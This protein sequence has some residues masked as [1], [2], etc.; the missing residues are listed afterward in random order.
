M[1]GY[2]AYFLFSFQVILLFQKSGADPNVSMRTVPAWSHIQMIMNLG[3]SAKR[4]LLVV[5]LLL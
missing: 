5:N 3:S 1:G 2:V 4:R